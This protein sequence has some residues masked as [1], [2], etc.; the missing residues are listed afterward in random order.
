MG[1]R[2]RRGH[3]VADKEVKRETRLGVTDPSEKSGGA[4]WGQSSH[5]ASPSEVADLLSTQTTRK[6]E[7]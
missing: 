4:A 5:T 2:C 7:N 6:S 3:A 1:V